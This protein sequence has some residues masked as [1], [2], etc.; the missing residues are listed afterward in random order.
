MVVISQQVFD[1]FPMDCICCKF[2]L[3]VPPNS[4]PNLNLDF[5]VD[6]PH[7]MDLICCSII[8]LSRRVDFLKLGRDCGGCWQWTGRD[9]IHWLESSLESCKTTYWKTEVG[10]GK[11]HWGGTNVAATQIEMA[12]AI[13]MSGGTYMGGTVM[14][15]QCEEV[16]QR[17]STMR[18]Y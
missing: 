8:L 10:N 4:P 15:R 14:L 13:D 7:L 5:L 2:S 17:R 1:N 6:F 9:F 18:D 12:S 16:R 11:G 3:P